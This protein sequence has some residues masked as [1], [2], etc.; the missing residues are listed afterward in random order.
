MATPLKLL[1]IL[2]AEFDPALLPGALRAVNDVSKLDCVIA[3]WWNGPGLFTFYEADIPALFARPGHG[4]KQVTDCVAGG[5]FGESVDV[6]W[7]QVGSRFRAVLVA[8]GVAVSPLLAADKAVSVPWQEAKEEVK[9]RVKD[10]SEQV[11]LWG[12]ECVGLTAEGAS[13]WVEARIPRRLTYPVRPQ[14]QPDNTPPDKNFDGVLLHLTAYLDNRGRVIV[15]RRRNL[16]AQLESEK[17]RQA[18]RGGRGQDALPAPEGAE[19]GADNG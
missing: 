4:A 12:T 16:T 13:V 8:E 15:Y 6:S 1:S 18:R 17:R 7:R 10:K 19:E 9:R 14:Q 5:S 3:D 2:Y 11:I